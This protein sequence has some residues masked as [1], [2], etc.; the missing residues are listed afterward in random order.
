[1][2]QSLGDTKTFRLPLRVEGG[3]WLRHIVKDEDDSP[4][5]LFSCSHQQHGQPT[6]DEDGVPWP[7][8]LCD[9]LRGL[10]ARVTREG[11]KGFHS[12]MG[13][14]RSSHPRRENRLHVNSLI[15]HAGLSG[16]RSQLRN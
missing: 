7:A 3:R 13:V 1:M 10:K 15:L 9:T 4:A 16:Q 2:N 14:Q 6:L 5:L 8:S 11:I 12:R